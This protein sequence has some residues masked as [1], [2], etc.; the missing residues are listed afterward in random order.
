MA[1]RW[2]SGMGLIITVLV[3]NLISAQA[4]TSGAQLN[5]ASSH[6]A[7]FSLMPASR[8][9][10]RSASDFDFASTAAGGSLP[11][12]G[13]GTVGRLTKW[14]GITSSNSFIAD[15]TI[16]ENKNGLVGIGTDTPTSKLTVAGMVEITLGGLKFPDG[17][18]QT[19]SAAGALFTVSHDM[20]LQGNGTSG[21]PLAVAVPLV[22]TGSSSPLGLVRVT[23]TAAQGIGV[24][25]AGGPEGTG[26]AATGGATSGS[27]HE[28]GVGVR[29]TGGGG[30][31]GAPGGPGVVAFAGDSDSLTGGRGIEAHGGRSN[32]GD[33]GDGA[34][35]GGGQ[36]FGGSGGVG[37]S[38]EGGAGSGA[39]NKGGDGIM[40]RGGDGISG[41]TDGIAG[42][43][44]GDVE[45]TG[46][47]TVTSGMKMFH[48]DHPLDPENKYLNHVA[49][50]SA[51][52]LNVYS[53]N[54][55]TDTNGEAVVALPDWFEALNRDF[56]YH[57]TV[58]GT[59]AQA[60][61][62]GKIKGNRFA[63]RTNAPNIEVSWQVTGVRSDPTTRKFPLEVEEAKSER[64]RG[65]YLNPGAYGQPEERGME[66]ARYPEMMQRMKRQRVEAEQK[67]KQQQR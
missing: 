18:V 44:A 42:H 6:P 38:A 28:G 26:V 7:G 34:V 17:T 48:I 67:L 59:F 32:S 10:K 61:I 64:E 24:Y 30:S 60:I 50:E 33:G 35:L 54:I 31:S 11:V 9:L 21:S 45:I 27:G 62:A 43:F 2:L 41:A 47:L 22:L 3:L 52:V 25:G 51:E 39:G 5:H 46:K 56:R 1:K 58:V 37:A 66:W 20:T 12:L 19:T 36:S 29:A 65:Y 13:S 8:A 40:A 63:I 15:T 53:G 23:N 16:F 14:T 57:L 49:I 4:Q 55:T